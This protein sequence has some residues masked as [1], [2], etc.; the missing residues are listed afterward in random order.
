MRDM[1][2]RTEKATPRPG[3][4]IIFAKA[5]DA[6]DV[7]LITASGHEQTLATFSTLALAYETAHG[8]TATRVWRRHHSDPNVTEP[9]KA[10]NIA[11]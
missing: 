3:D 1:D 11:T 2:R 7:I 5:D 4:H 10:S 9:Y 6:Y 8:L